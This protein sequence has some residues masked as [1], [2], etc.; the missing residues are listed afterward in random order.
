[1]ELMYNL[2]DLGLMFMNSLSSL[3]QG[4]MVLLTCISCCLLKVHNEDGGGGLS[5]YEG[6][7]HLKF[8]SHSPMEP[9]AARLAAHD[10]NQEA[11]LES[12][13]SEV[14]NGTA[15]GTA[16]ATR[17]PNLPQLQTGF[18][19]DEGSPGR[20]R[21]GPNILP[22]EFRALEACLEA[23]CSSLDNEVHCSLHLQLS[24][25]VT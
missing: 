7:G 24:C 15:N 23:A 11:L 8:N 14:Q 9:L 19:E 25:T 22:F 6:D 2:H 3:I 1:M 16:A 5:D 13:K 18:K 4:F 17:F 20:T 21:G 10:L 12:T